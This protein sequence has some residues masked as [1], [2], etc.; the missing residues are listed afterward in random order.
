MNAVGSLHTQWRRL[1]LYRRIY[2]V[3]TLQGQTDQLPSRH[4]NKRQRSLGGKSRA[5]NNNAIQQ[6][7]HNSFLTLV[8]AMCCGNDSDSRIGFEQV[9][10]PRFMIFFVFPPTELA[11]CISKLPV[12]DY[13]ERHLRHILLRNYHLLRK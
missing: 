10:V 7:H 8:N 5:T 2:S 12:R 3:H 13:Y 1:L 6:M 4:Q 9:M 11:L